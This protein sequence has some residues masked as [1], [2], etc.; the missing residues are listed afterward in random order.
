MM[1]IS[2]HLLNNILDN[3][4]QTPSDQYSRCPY[5]PHLINIRI[6]TSHKYSSNSPL[7]GCLK[8]K[9]GWGSSRS[10]ELWRRTTYGVSKCDYRKQDHLRQLQ[11]TPLKFIMGKCVARVGAQK[12]A[13]TL[14]AQGISM[15]DNSNSNSF[16]SKTYPITRI[17]SVALLL[18]PGFGLALPECKRCQS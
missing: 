17:I 18:Y 5:K 14:S 9:S 15:E 7:F 4:I 6:E 16:N 1:P 12:P 8:V 2:K 13:Q 3:E 10:L 11:P